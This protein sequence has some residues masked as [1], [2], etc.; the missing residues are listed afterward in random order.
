MIE[1]NHDFQPSL[2]DAIPFSRFFRALKD[3]AKVNCRS[4]GWKLDIL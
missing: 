4:R 2:R 1:W 3:P